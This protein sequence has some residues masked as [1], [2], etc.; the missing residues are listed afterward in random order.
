L[1]EPPVPTTTPGRP[2]IP[3]SR[4]WGREPQNRRELRLRPRPG[5]GGTKRSLQGGPGG[6][7]CQES[8]CNEKR[9][10][11][12]SSVRSP[13]HLRWGPARPSQPRGHRRAQLRGVRRRP[14]EALPRVRHPRPHPSSAAGLGPACGE[15]R[16]GEREVPAPTSDPPLPPPP[17]RPRAGSRLPQEASDLEG[18]EGARPRA[19]ASQAPHIRGFPVEAG[20]GATPR[21]PD[22]CLRSPEKGLL[23]AT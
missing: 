23:Q 16:G 3:I 4:T 7:P 1:G 13:A 6:L 9:G 20:P 8:M 12:M 2:A 11:G 19:Q 15:G 10:E 21:P 14:E 17:G 18:W 22:P 5:T